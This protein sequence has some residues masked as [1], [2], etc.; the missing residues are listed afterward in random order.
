MD[1]DLS[2]K[3]ILDMARNDTRWISRGNEGVKAGWGA[4]F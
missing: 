4:D 3:K 2:E 1:I